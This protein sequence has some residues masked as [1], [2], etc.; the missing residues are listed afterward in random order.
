MN[1]FPVDSKLT[2]DSIEK[3]MNESI[4]LS[5]C[6]QNITLESLR[7]ADKG[8]IATYLSNR[9]LELIVCYII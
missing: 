9:L 5:D 3:Q 4:S 8:E 7:A 6:S 2:V 1:C